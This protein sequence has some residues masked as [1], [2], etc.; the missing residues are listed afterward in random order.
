V[1]AGSPRHHAPELRAADRRRSLQLAQLAPLG[2][3]PL[4][5]LQ[6]GEAAG[7]AG[8]ALLDFTVELNDF[9]DTA[10]LVAALDLVVS[11]DTAVAHL[12]GGLGV[13]VWVL[14]RFDTCWRWLLGRD[15]SPW[16]ASA[17]LFRQPAM[18]DWDSV[19]KAVA[20]ALEERYG[21]AV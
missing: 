18:G 12:A 9:D 17:R 3:V 16:Y 8:V 20:A 1:W 19:I 11:V 10:A 7:Q 21:Q 15:D 5:S 2:T 14:N 13:P 4:V 6:K